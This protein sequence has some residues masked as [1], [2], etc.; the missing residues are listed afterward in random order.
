MNLACV[1]TIN[2]RKWKCSE[3]TGEKIVLRPARKSNILLVLWRVGN[4]MSQVQGARHFGVS[5]AFMCMMESGKRPIPQR[6]IEIIT[7]PTL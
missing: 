3:S 4:G 2:G 6:V 5:A 1:I 7:K